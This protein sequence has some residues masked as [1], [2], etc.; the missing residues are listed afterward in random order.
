MGNYMGCKKVWFYFFFSPCILSIL[1]LRTSFYYVFF[2]L[3]ACIRTSPEK[4]APPKAKLSKFGQI[5]TISS[6]NTPSNLVYCNINQSAL[7]TCS[8]VLWKLE[9]TAFKNFT[10]WVI[11]LTSEKKLLARIAPARIL[12]T[13]ITLLPL[14]Q[15]NPLE[16]K[17]M[18]VENIWFVLSWILCWLLRSIQDTSSSSKGCQEG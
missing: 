15:H 18:A 13:H 6:C 10:S 17:R 8:L 3:R 5:Q 9:I 12:H 14:Y 2:L 1:Y 7:A 16:R 4:K 11:P